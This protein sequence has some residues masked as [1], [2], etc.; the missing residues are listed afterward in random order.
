MI[1]WFSLRSERFYY[2]LVCATEL[3]KNLQMPDTHFHYQAEEVLSRI[4]RGSK[5]VDGHNS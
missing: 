5:Y 4:C 3:I 2:V 1:N